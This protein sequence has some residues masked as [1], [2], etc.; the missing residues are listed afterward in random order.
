M[1][2]KVNTFKRILVSAAVIGLTPLL[3]AP[4]GGK[5]GG[6]GG[7]TGGI[8]SYT[9]DLARAAFGLQCSSADN[10]GRPFY[11]GTTDALTDTD[12]T[13]T[14]GTSGSPGV[15]SVCYCDAAGADHNFVSGGAAFRG[16]AGTAG[17]AGE[18]GA[19][20]TNGAAG[21]AGAEGPAGPQGPLGPE[22][23]SGTGSGHTVQEEGA[24]ILQRTQMNFIGRSVTAADDALNTKT[25]VTV[26]PIA[27][28]VLVTPTIDSTNDVQEIITKWNTSKVNTAD[29]ANYP[30]GSA[31]PNTAPV[32]CTTVG[33]FYLQVNANPAI[34]DTI[35][36]CKHEGS[37]AGAIWDSLT[38]ASEVTF[39][40]T[41]EIDEDTV[42]AAIVNVEAAKASITDVAKY[43]TV[44]ADPMTAGNTPNCTAAGDIVRWDRTDPLEDRMYVCDDTTPDT[45]H[46][47]GAEWPTT[48]MV[49]VDTSY[50]STPAYKAVML[51]EYNPADTGYPTAFLAALGYLAKPII[52]VTTALDANSGNMQIVTNGPIAFDL[53][54]ITAGQTVCVVDEVGGLG[55]C[56]AASDQRSV[57][58][59]AIT[60]GA[61]GVLYVDPKLRIGGVNPTFE[62]SCLT[63]AHVIGDL[64]VTTAAVTREFGAPTKGMVTSHWADSIQA[65]IT[66]VA[67]MCITSPCTTAT[68]WSRF[69]PQA[70]RGLPE[71]TGSAVLFVGDSITLGVG[72]ECWAQRVSGACTLNGGSRSRIAALTGAMPG[73]NGFYL[74]SWGDVYFGAAFYTG[75][76]FG[77]GMINF[78][79]LDFVDLHPEVSDVVFMVGTN[80][81]L[82]GAPCKHATTVDRTTAPTT[83]CAY[84]DTI[85][86]MKYVA[87]EL[88]A[89]GVF[90]HWNLSPGLVGRQKSATYT[91]VAAEQA[92][93]MVFD[94]YTYCASTPAARRCA[95][96]YA[97]Y[98]EGCAGDSGLQDPLTTGNADSNA[99]SAAN[100]L[101]FGD[102]KTDGTGGDE[103]NAVNR[104]AAE[105]FFNEDPVAAFR[106]F[107]GVTTSVAIHPNG[108]GHSMLTRAMA[109]AIAAADPYVSASRPGIA[110][111]HSIF[112][113]QYFAKKPAI[114]DIDIAS[115]TSTT[116]N[117]IVNRGTYVNGTSGTLGACGASECEYYCWATCNDYGTSLG[118]PSCSDTDA[119]PAQP[120]QVRFI[121]AAG[122]AQH[123]P[124]DTI[125]GPRGIVGPMEDG[126]TKVIRGLYTGVKYKVACVAASPASISYPAV[127][128]VTTP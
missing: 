7:G 79:V 108:I 48:K 118:D 78:D 116:I 91:T 58:G 90:S 54:S 88:G 122:G 76:L 74:G 106:S 115:K 56:T 52:G 101:D 82:T 103:A 18:A 65:G 109:V 77:T 45:V 19:D 114:P 55:A 29:L 81:M 117:V 67:Y 6:G 43:I 110:R 25:L 95:A 73:G 121:G 12:C 62:A 4:S 87:G 120:S 35:W 66:P 16:P 27:D 89:R 51:D 68:N 39:S 113:S 86:N 59:Y 63:T 47:I 83:V 69:T 96:N 75:H 60:G 26:A 70:P 98:V 24:S 49:Y 41:A 33:D 34:P 64:C 94:M 10:N 61:T 100:T 85:A 30:S 119:S 46:E 20:G 23:P 42:Q 11:F 72:D 124:G 28:D 93:K 80:D 44:T 32:P 99:C 112:G 105:Y 127:R 2:I 84:A 57:V 40:A 17:A 128:L 71:K 50:G 1:S 125:D 3:M 31:N 111:R 14:D 5:S 9:E 126:E 36:K 53:G 22:G 37:P 97:A 102:G 38:T 13:L 123:R 21:A 104:V 92:Q 15:G 107:G 8:V